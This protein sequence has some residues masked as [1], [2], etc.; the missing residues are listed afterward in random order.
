MISFALANRC[1]KPC[2]THVN[3]AGDAAHAV[4]QAPVR[5]SCFAILLTE[6]SDPYRLE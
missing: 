5:S 3:L 4:L 6:S 1:A 2:A